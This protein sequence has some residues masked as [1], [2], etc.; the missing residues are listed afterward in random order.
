MFDEDDCCEG[1]REEATDELYEHECNELARDREFDDSDLEDAED[2]ED[3][4]DDLP[5]SEDIPDPTDDGVPWSDE[6]VR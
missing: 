6:R 4:E 1:D 3:E 2:E 5:V